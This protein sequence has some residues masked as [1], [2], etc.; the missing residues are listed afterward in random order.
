VRVICLDP[1]RRILLL[2]WR[3]PVDGHLLWEP[4]GGGIE[5]GE[6]EVTAAHR[7]LLEETGIEVTLESGRRVLVHRDTWWCGRRYVGEEPFFLARVPAAHPVRPAALTTEEDG[8]LIEGRWLTWP[9]VHALTDPLEPPTLGKA[10]RA[11][12]PGG[13]WSRTSGCG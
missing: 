13:P 10:L 2:H 12:D 5:P 9:E 7:E 8:A 11:L 1:A 6:D 3:D 4:P